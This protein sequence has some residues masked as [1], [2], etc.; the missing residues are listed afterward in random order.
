[1]TAYSVLIPA[2]MSIEITVEADSEEEAKEKAFDV[3]F[4]LQI[5]AEESDKEKIY[6]H[7]FE[8]HQHVTTGN[9]CYAV[10]N[11]IEVIEIEV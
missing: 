1:M 9:V 3:P 11:D 8:L 10:L 2:T 7:E 6:L 4:E 5:D